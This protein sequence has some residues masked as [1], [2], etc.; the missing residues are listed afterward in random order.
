MLA[1][2]KWKMVLVAVV[3]VDL[4]S[5]VRDQEERAGLIAARDAERTARGLRSAVLDPAVPPSKPASSPLLILVLVSIVTMGG[6]VGIAIL[7]EHLRCSE[8][9]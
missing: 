9:G 7:L 8:K 3:A 2:P 5:T 4:W 6:A 1:Y